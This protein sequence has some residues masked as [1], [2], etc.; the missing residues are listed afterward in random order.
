MEKRTGMVKANGLELS[1]E[2]FG[3][4]KNEPVLMVMGLG[5]QHITWPDE[6]VEAIANA[7]Y[8]VVRYDNRDV[9]ESTKLD[10]LGIPNLRS[11]LLGRKPPYRIKDMA[12]DGFALMDAMGI[13]AAHV[14]GAS[15]GGFISQTMAIMAPDRIR[16]LTLI[17]TSTGS[18]SVGYPK[19]SV[20]R[21][22]LLREKVTSREDAMEMAVKSARIIGNPGYPVDEDAIADLAGRSYDRGYHPAGFMRQLAAVMA[23]PNRTRHLQKL[24]IPTLVVH[25]LDD[26]LVSVSGGMALAKAIPGSRFVG[27]PGMGH[28]M[29]REL[30][31]T[32]VKEI[33]NLARFGNEKQDYPAPE[34]PYLAPTP[35]I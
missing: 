15:M 30:W 33:L 4:P 21:T 29:P 7:G 34:D 32:V 24:K 18:R 16:T 13:T 26:N 20:W 3:D 25:G 19:P 14:I 10:H 6:I 28:G 22:M 2:T 23:Q 11:V 9:G 27:F 12:A 5:A 35:S 1:Y 31:P 17:M 8:W